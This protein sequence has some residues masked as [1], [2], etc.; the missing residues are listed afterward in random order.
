MSSMNCLHEV[1]M[2]ER[3]P[4][5]YSHK[6]KSI[7]HRGDNGDNGLREYASLVIAAILKTVMRTLKPG[8]TEHDAFSICW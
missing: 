2:I 3:A 4:H 1:F 7:E 8:Y 5:K 6:N